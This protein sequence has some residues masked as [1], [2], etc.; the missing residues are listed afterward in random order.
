MVEELCERNLSKPSHCVLTAT[1]EYGALRKHIRILPN[2][3]RIEY[4]VFRVNNKYTDVKCEVQRKHL[5][6]NGI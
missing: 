4:S 5:P 1:I 6:G 3:V 2:T